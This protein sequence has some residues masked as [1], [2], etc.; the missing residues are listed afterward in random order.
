MIKLSNPGLQRKAS[1]IQ[2]AVFTLASVAVTALTFGAPAVA[3]QADWKAEWNARVQ[4]ARRVQ[5]HPCGDMIFTSW[6]DA[7]LE[8]CTRSDPDPDVKCWA[9]KLWVQ[10]RLDQCAPWTRYLK[11]NYN[12]RKRD[13][14]RMPPSAII[15]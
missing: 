9:R 3:Q 5:E 11:R 10:T 4:N 8:P 12:K 15:D 6:A 2:S 14:S 1:A 7:F 13:D